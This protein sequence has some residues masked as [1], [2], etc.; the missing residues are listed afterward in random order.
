DF[1]ATA[2]V[3]GLVWG[4]SMGIERIVMAVVWPNYF[5]RKH[6]GSISGISMAMVVTGS[7]LGPLPLGIAFDLFG[8]YTEILW[9]LMIFPIF[10]IWAALP[11]HPQK[12]EA[13][14]KQ[15]LAKQIEG[16]AE[17]PLLAE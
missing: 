16:P 1:L 15:P 14:L 13:S 9:A 11:A 4:V 8:G 12:N 2:M 17:T 7:A 6:I 3:F 5:G 10:G